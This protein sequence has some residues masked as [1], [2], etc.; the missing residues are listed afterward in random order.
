MENMTTLSAKEQVR[1]V[2]EDIVDTEISPGDLELADRVAL[3]RIAG[4]STELADVSEVEYRQLRLERVVLVGVW[5][6]G[7]A[8]QSDASLAELARLAETAGSQVLE[9][10]VQRRHRVDPATYIGSGKVAELGSIV[11]AHAAD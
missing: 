4:L 2:L 6:E 1:S 10:I 9:G 5:I 11:R 8:A 7:T 3:R